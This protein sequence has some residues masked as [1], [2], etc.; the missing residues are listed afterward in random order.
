[1]NE[2]CAAG[3]GKFFEA[4]SRALHCSLEELS[5]LALESSTPVSITQQCSVFAES[6]VVGLLNTGGDRRDIAA[7]IHNSIASRLCSMLFRVG[8]MPDVAVTGG[9]AKNNALRK[10]LEQKLGCAIVQLPENPQ[11][12]GALGAALFAQDKAGKSVRG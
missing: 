9:C 8:I 6:E 3:T 7:G 11:I 5:T 1:M 12:V 10:S 2:K 4:M